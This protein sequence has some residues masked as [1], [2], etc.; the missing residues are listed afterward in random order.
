MVVMLSPFFK[1]KGSQ[2]SF[3]YGSSSSVAFGVC[4]VGV[5]ERDMLGAAALFSV[6]R[7]NL[8]GMSL[9]ESVF[10]EEKTV[11]VSNEVGGW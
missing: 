4:F 1:K 3:V 2:T 9:R 11:S 10:P 7:C 6:H 5:C 8:E